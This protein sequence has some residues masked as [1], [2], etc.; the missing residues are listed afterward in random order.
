MKK[1]KKI[2]ID[3]SSLENI[4][5]GFGQIA[6]AYGNY[7]KANYKRIDANY[8][9]TL[10]VPKP[11]FGMF[12]DEVN[13]ISSSSWIKRHFSVS[14]PEFDVWHAIHQLSRFQP[15]NKRTTF[16]LTIHDLHYL[17]ETTGKRRER[18]HQKMQRK[19]QRADQIVCISEHTRQ[20]VYANLVLEDKP[21]SVIYNGVNDLAKQPK[22]TPAEGI[23][24][25][26]FFTIGAVTEKK[27]FHV[28]LD[29]MKLMPDHHLY[30]VGDTSRGE[31]G[32]VIQRRIEQEGI[33]NVFLLGVISEPEKVWFYTNCKA[34]LFPSLLEGFGLPIIEAM[35]FGKPVFSSKETSLKEIGGKFVYFW[36]NFEPQHMK[37]V[38]DIHLGRFYQDE[39]LIREEMEYAFSFSYEKH[40]SEYRK[41]Y[42]N[43]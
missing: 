35:Q 1:L 26:F 16:I 37:S 40:F 14:F 24:C 43:L 10:L 4:Y 17:Y 20:E 27:N 7:F 19:V 31:Y 9:L 42:E 12:G 5:C 29:M 8:S 38:I 25:P 34:F 21:C 36:E 23:K 22:K 15:A 13:Y 18:M 2:L 6:L 28:L 11:M 32:S 41:L 33:R 30:I 39:G 3:L